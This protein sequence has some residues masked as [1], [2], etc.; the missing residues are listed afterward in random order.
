MRIPLPITI[1]SCLLVAY[2]MWFLG[3]YRLDFTTPPTPD[4]LIETTQQWEQSRPNIPRPKAIKANL[5]IDKPTS[6]P[7]TSTTL[8]RIQ[9]E[10][11]PTGN[12]QHAPALAEYGTLGNKGGPAMAKLATLLETQGEIQRAR[13]AWERVIDTADPDESDR[14]LAVTAIKRLSANLP[15]WNP[16]PTADIALT[17]HAGATLK[18]SEALNE[19][20]TTVARLITEASGNVVSVNTKTSI[21][22]S[23]GIK[24]PRIP[25]AIWFSRPGTP[26]A[27]T[28][29]ISFMAD[30]NLKNMLASQIEAGVYAL[31]RAHLA[32]ETSF[33]PLPEYPTGVKPD[34][35]IKYHITRLMWREFVNSMEE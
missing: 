21:G 32:T 28:S 3:T 1:I 18:D 4:Q 15:P 13:L 14:I 20:L 16:D 8:A 19:A 2:V 30:P 24:T 9:P 35:L 23:R 11:L 29:P 26:P 12:L 33:S 7:Q 6:S 17:L 22:K 27:E 5:T 31:L 25:I 10:T 34:D